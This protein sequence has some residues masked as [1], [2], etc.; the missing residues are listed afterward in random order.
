MRKYLPRQSFRAD[1]VGAKKLF[2]L[3]VHVRA[4]GALLRQELTFERPAD[5][6][7]SAFFREHHEFGLRDRGII[8]EGA[9]FAMRHLYEISWRMKPTL[10]REAV[11]LMALL[12]YAMQYGDKALEGVGAKDA[13]AVRGFL[14]RTISSAPEYIRADTPSWL[15]KKIADQYE[16]CN[17]L[18]EA[19]KEPAPLDIRTNTLKTNRDMLLGEFAKLHYEAYPSRFSPDGI[20]LGRKYALTSLAIFR[21]GFFDVQDEGSQLVARLVEPRRREMVCDFCAGAGGKTLAMGALMRNSG[22]LY[23]FDVNQKRLQGLQPRMKRAGLSNVYTVPIRN[24]KDPRV[25]RM[26]EKFDRVLVD[27]PCS[28]TGTWRRNPDLKFRISPEEL[29]RIRELQRSILESAAS[30]V[31]EGGRLVYATCSLLR[32]ENQENAEW[33][34]Q[35]HSEFSLENAVEILDGQNISLPESVRADAP[36]LALSPQRSDT[37][38]FFAA[39]FSK[40]PGRYRNS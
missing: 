37:D 39:V 22:R 20:R 23:A 1:G 29:T 4:L 10:P 11:N 33:F 9:F 13:E 26:R 8:A 5:A 40:T 34:I 30:L 25:K 36:Y 2:I 3:P 6:V 38:G 16:D 35:N 21:E 12:C 14:A 7:M 24:E 27:A 32:E 18:F 31:K 15:F 17:F 28:G 19:M